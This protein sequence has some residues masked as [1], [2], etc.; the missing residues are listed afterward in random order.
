M[1]INCPNCDQRVLLDA[2]KLSNAPLQ[3]ICARCGVPYRIS[4]LCEKATVN[5]AAAPAALAS[6]P[7]PAEKTVPA[8]PPR[9]GEDVLALPHADSHTEPAAEPTCVVLDLGDAHEALRRA[10][11][12]TFSEDKYRLGARLL[13]VSPLR[14]LLAGIAFVALVGFCDMLLAPSEHAGD[15]AIAAS[16][17]NQATNRTASRPRRDEAGSDDTRDARDA[18]DDDSDATAQAS[19]DSAATKPAPISDPATSNA[20]SAATANFAATDSAATTSAPTASTPT[21]SAST[22]DP[23]PTAVAV[24]FTNVRQELPADAASVEQTATKVTIQLASYRVEDEAQKLAASLQAAGFESRVV[25]EQHSKRPWY[26]V[27]TKIFDTRGDAEQYLTE[28][29]AKHLA[30]SYT[31]REIE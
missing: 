6:A 25:T 7:R 1:R 15:D 4:L 30:S 16:L 26:C 27:Q 28:L 11:T 21:A 2:A 12:R 9:D 22:V 18:R 3:T 24:S 17:Q 20:D 13:N 5:A 29:R 10:R 8:A 31:V 14:L 23:A 19:E